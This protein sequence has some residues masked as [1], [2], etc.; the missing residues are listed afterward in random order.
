MKTIYILAFISGLLM[1]AGMVVGLFAPFL[2]E[3][4]G[5]IGVMIPLMIFIAVL[6]VSMAERGY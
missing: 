4:L 1:T 5:I 6:F 3:V 2:G